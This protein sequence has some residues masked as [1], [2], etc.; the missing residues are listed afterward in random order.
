V[1]SLAAYST[2]LAAVVKSGRAQQADTLAWAAGEAVSARCPP[3]DTLRVAGAFLLSIPKSTELRAQVVKLY[4]A[5][6]ADRD[7]LEALLEEAGVGGGRP[8]RRAL[9]TVETCLGLSVGDHLIE[10]HGPGAARIDAIDTTDWTFTVNTGAET[11]RLGAVRLADAYYAGPRDAL[12]VMRCF[13]REDLIRRLQTSPVELVIDICRRSDGRTDKPAL[14]SLL[15]PDLLD[16]DAWK[17]WWTRARAAMKQSPCLRLAS[18]APYAIEYVENPPEPGEALLDA[19]AASADP[20][21]GF[22]QVEQYVRECRARR[23]DPDAGVLTACCNHFVDQARRLQGSGEARAGLLWL[24]ARRIGELAGTGDASDGAEAYLR[25]SA[26]VEAVLAVVTDESLLADACA[27]VIEG[28]PA[29][30]RAQVLSLL[31]T[32]SMAVCDRVA[33]KLGDAGCTAADFAP[34]V[35]RILASPVVHNDALLW[36]WNGP[37]TGSVLGDVS[38]VTV[39]SRVIAALEECQRRDTLSRE[40]VRKVA[41]RTRSVLS[42]RGYARYRQCLDVLDR[43]MADALRTRLRRLS[44]LGHTVHQRLL[45]LLARK[46]PQIDTAPKIEP[47]RRDDVLFV[48]EHGLRNKQREI[49][50][51]INVKMKENARAIGA[52]AAKGDLSENSEYKFALEERDLLRARLA[53]MNAELEIAEILAPED[54]PTDHIGVGTR[55]RM[56][57][58]GDGAAYELCFLGPWEADGD[59]G[60]VNYRAPLAQRVLGKVVG[61]LV[62]FDHTAASGTYE[63]VSLHNAL[64]E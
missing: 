54:V 38:P 18:R 55:V 9:R 3:L 29:D 56:R 46:F 62:E 49:D 59:R 19:V 16:A 13:Y 52:A 31:P 60:I 42:A 21:G 63:I 58:V 51:H 5:A 7:G 30:G 15:V 61:D 35:Q 36:L 22:S 23:T 47:W 41:T 14:E 11:V 12:P 26:D 27:L 37:A 2:V 20:A 34:V 28:R 45:N 43:G 39:L 57:R 33:A 50:E 1:S 10:R 44:N 32:F 64:A 48:T 17:K 8:V 53:Q 40:V 6:Y 4:R 25:K 24:I